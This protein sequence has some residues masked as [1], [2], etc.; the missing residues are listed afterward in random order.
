M[1]IR[2]Q[3]KEVLMQVVQREGSWTSDEELRIDHDVG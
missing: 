3:Q 2:F 1:T